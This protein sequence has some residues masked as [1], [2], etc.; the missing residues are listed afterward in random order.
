MSTTADAGTDVLAPAR[1]ERDPSPVYRHPAGATLTRIL[2]WGAER[3]GDRTYCITLGPDGEETAGLT[4]AELDLRVRAVA[5]ELRRLARPGDRALLLLPQGTDF[6]TAFFACSYAGVIAVPAPCPDSPSRARRLRERLTGIVADARPS[7]VLTVAEVAAGDALSALVGDMPRLVVRDTDTGLADTWRDPG[8]DRD[9]V[10]LLQYTSGS[11]SGAK[12]VV[13]TQGNVTENLAAVAGALGEDVRENGGDGTFTNVTWLPA[14][15]DMGLATLLLP[16]YLGGRCVVLD[17]TAFLLDPLLWLRAVDHYGARMSTAPNFAYDLCVDR[18]APEHRRELDLSRWRVAMSGAEPVRAATLSRFAA[19][20]AGTGFRSSAFMPCYGMA[21]ANV[22]VSG[23][24]R[25]GDTRVL[26]VR[27][28]ELETGRTVE[29]ATGEDAG[30][31]LV[32]LGGLPENLTALIVDPDTRRPLPQAR[33]G[34]IWLTGANIGQGYWGNPEASAETFGA[35]LADTG[36][37]PFLR[38]RDLGF[39]QDGQLYVTGRTDD[40]IIVDGRN[41]HPQD[42]ELTAEE[43]HPAI[44]RSRVAAFGWRDGNETRVVVVAEISRRHRVVRGD[45]VEAGRTAVEE[46]VRAVRESVREAHEVG[47][48]DVVLL[49]GALPRTTSGK[50]QRGR[51]RKLFLEGALSTW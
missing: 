29:P 4:Y 51:T 7:V 10:A 8:T 36:E 45:A 22:Y 16:C 9:T 39:F 21:E 6:V 37:G 41:I 12:G 11:T 38:T 23:H 34:E 25:P 26:R 43:S 44:G 27:A 20:F 18:I 3:H 32:G 5:A 30:R 13:L 15:H 42:I 40:L 19:A 31:P 1:P 48:A 50:I 47:V 28:R 24:R 2:R 14:F 17:P 46:I 35:R 49:K 33:V